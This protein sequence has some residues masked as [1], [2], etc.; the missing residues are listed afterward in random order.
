MRVFIKNIFIFLII[1]PLLF[2]GISLYFLYTGKYKETVEG[3]VVYNV[4]ARSKTKWKARKLL[5]GDSVGEQLFPCYQNDETIVSLASNES[6]GMMGQYLLLNNFIN[7]GN[8]IDTLY[9]LFNPLSFQNNM[10]GRKKYQFFLKTFY[11]DE[12]KPLFL[13]S[14]SNQLEKIPYKSICQNPCVKTTDWVPYKGL[15][16]SEEGKTSEMFLSQVSADCINKMK[17]LSI[18]HNFKIL[19][20]PSPV[21]LSNKQRILALDRSLIEK[22]D[23]TSDFKNYF[24]DIIFLE[25]GNFM[26]GYHLNKPEDYREFYISH[27]MK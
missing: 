6:I 16:N 1:L 4:I 8:T 10:D 5:L 18:L 15:F 13:K 26:D 25:K 7:A 17:Q 11:T 3:S 2:Y 22:N 21:I 27:L 9:L 12:Y 24:K 23:L 19:V 14:V 20:L